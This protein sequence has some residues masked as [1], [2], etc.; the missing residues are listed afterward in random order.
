MQKWI[1]DGDYVLIV[2]A[3]VCIN[4]NAC[5]TKSCTLQSTEN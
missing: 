3:I 1:I 4:D 2:M 5:E